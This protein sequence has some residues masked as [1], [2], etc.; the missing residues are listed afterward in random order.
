MSPMEISKLA[1]SIAL[2]ALALVVIGAIGNVLV[3]PEK[4]AAP[5][6]SMA[7]AP[8]ERAPEAA[9]PEP[10]MP[11]SARLAAADAEQGAKVFRKCKA[12]HTVEQGGRNAIGPNLWNVVGSK[13]AHREDFDY[14]S[15]MRQAGGEW[16]YDKLDAFLARP[17]EALPGTKMTFAGLSRP[18]E[19]ADVI[20]YL[21]TLS[22][23]PPPLPSP[24]EP[25][26]QSGRR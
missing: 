24:P 10:E 2:V 26:R 13:L 1:A 8:A 15:A 3:R 14:S 11:I 17:R 9:K 21:R 5:A 25:A 16:T 19:R 4:E 22:D 18:D 20:A 6:V 12:C 23:S 7:S